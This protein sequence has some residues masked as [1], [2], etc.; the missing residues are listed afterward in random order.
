MSTQ[1][2]SSLATSVPSRVAP[3]RTRS[4]AGWRLRQTNSS[5]RSS[6]AFTGR[7]ALRASAATSASSRTNV[8]APNE[9][10]IGGAITRTSAS[11]IPN[12]WAMSARVLNGV[13]VPVHR[14]R[15]PP[16]HSA[17]AACGSIAACAAPGVRNA[18]C[19]TTSAPANPAST[20]PWRMRKRWQ[21]FVPGERAHA[22]RD[23]LSRGLGG[24]G[25]QQRRAGR[26]RLDRVEHRRQLLV[27]HLDRARGGPRRRRGRAGDRRHDV[28]RVPRDAGE[29]VLVA[30]LAAVGGEV[31]DVLGQQRD[32]VAG[33]RGRV[34]AQH[35]RVGVRGADERRVEHP[36]PLDV[37]RVALGAADARVDHASASSARRTSTATTRRRYAA[38][39]R[40]SPIG[41]IRSA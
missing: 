9:P 2:S 23:L 17:S 5:A 8:L 19:T 41:S 22:D 30:R 39:P 4:V 33:E 20:S 12:A 31:G 3:S 29:H 21:T 13:C 35:A 16:S 40:A 38:E 28:A 14:V 10:P 24:V 25:V 18:R 36:R 26:D 11:S 6:V 37:D 34:D 27:G 1:Q 32:A 7:P 15:R